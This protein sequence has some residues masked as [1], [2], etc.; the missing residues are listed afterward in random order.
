VAALINKDNPGYEARLK[1]LDLGV[2]SLGMKFQALAVRNQSEFENAFGAAAKEKA[3]ALLLMPDALFHSYPARIVE[4]AAKNKLPTMY[5]RIDF[6]EAGGLMSYGVNLAELS[7][8]SAWYVDQILKGSKPSD[9]TLVE[10]TKGELAVNLKAAQQIGVTI[11]S[12]V[13]SQAN[14]VIK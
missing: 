9:L 4:L 14:K 10:P 2:R 5:D 12:N 8:Q 7:R 11:P 1:E 13:L 6:V 3:E